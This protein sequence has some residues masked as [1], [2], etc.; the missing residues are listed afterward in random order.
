MEK[1]LGWGVEKIVYNGTRVPETAV[2][3][4]SL[5]ILSLVWA[6]AFLKETSNRH[7]QGDYL[8]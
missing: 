6:Q 7:I 4:D 3:F 2:N 8:D 1:G 5:P